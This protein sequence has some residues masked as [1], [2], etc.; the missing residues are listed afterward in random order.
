MFP[1]YFLFLTEHL[2]EN[3]QKVYDIYSTL[4]PVHA[5]AMAVKM[6]LNYC[7]SFWMIHIF[8][9]HHF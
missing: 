9:P 4:L 3:T 6:V 8:I 1:L 2:T 5:V 7:G